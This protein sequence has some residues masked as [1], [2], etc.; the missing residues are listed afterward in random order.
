MLVS[1][2]ADVLLSG[3][4]RFNRCGA[5]DHNGPK[6]AIGEYNRSVVFSVLLSLT[7]NS[8]NARY[9]FSYRDYVKAIHRRK[10]AAMATSSAIAQDYRDAPNLG[11]CEWIYS[12]SSAKVHG[13]IISSVRI[14]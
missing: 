4:I 8:R 3:F 1:I 10:L 11:T 2:S 13:T 9:L 14:H 7:L 5:S 12:T 6:K